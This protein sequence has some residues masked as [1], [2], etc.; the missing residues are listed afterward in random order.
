MVAMARNPRSVV[1][2]GME[3]LRAEGAYE[4]PVAVEETP[5]VEATEA[6]VLGALISQVQIM[7][8]RLAID[9]RLETLESMLVQQASMIVSLTQLVMTPRRRIPVRDEAG[10]I[11]EVMDVLVQPEPMSEYD[12]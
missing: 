9:T 6:E 2:I 8:D 4:E 11:I 1:D 10:N 5:A 3:I 7:V 12:G